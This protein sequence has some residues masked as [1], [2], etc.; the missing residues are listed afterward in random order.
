MKNPPL[1]TA[2]DEQERCCVLEEEGKAETRCPQK[3]RFWVGKQGFPDD[4]TYVC[5]GHVDDVR[6]EGDTVE[7]L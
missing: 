5:G 7:K 1:I 6:R 4:Y 3:A 2:P